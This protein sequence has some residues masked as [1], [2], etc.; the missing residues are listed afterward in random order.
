M[1]AYQEFAYKSGFSIVGLGYQ[2]EALFIKPMKLQ[3]LIA[4][5]LLSQYAAPLKA[6]NTS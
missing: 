3:L 2:S 5:V 4:E 6:L 1:L